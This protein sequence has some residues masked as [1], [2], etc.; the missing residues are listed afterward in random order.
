MQS[1]FMRK[2]LPIEPVL[3]MPFQSAGVG[4]MPRVVGHLD[5]LSVKGIVVHAVVELF[6]D[7]AADLEAELR[8]DCDVPCIKQ[9]VDIPP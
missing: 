4:A 5:A 8:C 7:P 1:A 3:I 6:L 2:K 9:T